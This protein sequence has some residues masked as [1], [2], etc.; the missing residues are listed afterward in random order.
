M[1]SEQKKRLRECQPPKPNMKINIFHNQNQDNNKPK[2]A[3]KG[4]KILIFPFFSPATFQVSWVLLK[5][6][7]YFRKSIYFLILNNIF[8]NFFSFDIMNV[9]E[10]PLYNNRDLCTIRTHFKFIS[11]LTF[12]LELL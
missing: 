8:F 7:K 10:I 4:R 5:I 9:S 3:G 6:I 11:F 12:N 2:K 1:K